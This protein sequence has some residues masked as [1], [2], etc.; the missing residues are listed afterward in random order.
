MFNILIKS[1]EL[2]G[3]IDNLELQ[4]LERRRMAELLFTITLI[5]CQHI[6]PAGPLRYVDVGYT[7][8]MRDI[9]NLI[10][11]GNACAMS[12]GAGHFESNL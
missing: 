1:Q 7:G 12:S 9:Q 2:L 11:S 4:S 6:S 10:R 8:C 3:T 5:M